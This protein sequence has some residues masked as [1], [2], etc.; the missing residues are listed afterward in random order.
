MSSY[1]GT[2]LCDPPFLSSSQMPADS[3]TAQAVLLLA[4]YYPFQE[5]VWPIGTSS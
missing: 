5:Q 2:K 1:L 3:M 4:A